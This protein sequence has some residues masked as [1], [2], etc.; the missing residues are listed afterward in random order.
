MGYCAKPGHGIFS[1]KNCPRCAA[2]QPA[3]SPVAPIPRAVVPNPV[4][5]KVP[6]IH[7][8]KIPMLDNK[9][10]GTGK[11]DWDTYFRPHYADPN[12]AMEKIKKLLA[13]YWQIFSPIARSIFNP[14]QRGKL[15]ELQKDV[16]T[17]MGSK[18]PNDP[19]IPA[20]VALKE[21]VDRTYKAM[22]VPPL[23]RR[24][25]NVVCIGYKVTTG[26]FEAD[27]VD[28]KI[29]KV[30][31]TGAWMDRTDMN[32]K[33]DQLKKAITQALGEYETKFG[34]KGKSGAKTKLH[35]TEAEDKDTLKIFMAPEFYFRGKQGGYDM[36]VVN[37]I[38]PEMRN[39]T[40]GDDYKHWLFVLGTAIAATRIYPTCSK[41]K[42]VTELMNDP[43]DPL[44]HRTVVWCKKCKKEET[45]NKPKMMLDNFAVIQK[46]GENT[47]A[48]AYLIQK[49]YMSWVDYRR[50]TLTTDW[51]DPANREVEVRGIAAEAIPSEGS[52]QPGSVARSKYD[53][54]RMGG[55]VFSMDG[56]RFGV[57]VC[58]DH[59]NGRLKNSKNSS[60]LNIKIQ[61]IP[62]A[63]VPQPVPTNLVAPI[64]FN[65]DGSY[66]KVRVMAN[67][68]DVGLSSDGDLCISDRITIPI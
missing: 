50:P 32:N 57:E 12:P 17:W 47:D 8:D 54:E 61:L 18:K 60:L 35:L 26:H 31:Y 20:M 13:E 52:S 29:L 55:S 38:L 6:T 28:P 64:V 14:Y 9:I 67:G 1:E 42:G 16:S 10:G 15:L 58:L 25:N 51:D 34:L 23:G 39:F 33:R 63:G 44:S 27:K 30:Q 40:K 49:E 4:Q 11:S 22:P 36:A 41:C 53:D 62:S 46:G 7:F 19:L 21:V 68:A 37:E 2:G 43:K 56:I 45:V 5:V 24:Y 59:L 66:A 48:N 3:R 65:V